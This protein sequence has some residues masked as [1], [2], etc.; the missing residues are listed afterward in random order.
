MT[1]YITSIF[2]I[3]FR[4]IVVFMFSILNKYRYVIKQE[5]CLY[6]KTYQY[7]TMYIDTGLHRCYTN[8]NKFIEFLVTAIVVR[9]YFFIFLWLPLSI[10]YIYPYSISGTC[11][12][13]D[14]LFFFKG[15]HLIR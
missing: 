13:V 15:V 12:F 8:I 6:K 2:I 9:S 11:I 7:D 14:Y 5:I 1:W 10:I 3:I 4:I